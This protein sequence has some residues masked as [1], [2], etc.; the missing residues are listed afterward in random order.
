MTHVDEEKHP[1]RKEPA[2]NVSDSDD[3]TETLVN[4]SPFRPRTT[5]KKARDDETETLVN[6]SPFRPRT[7]SPRKARED[8]QGLD[9]SLSSKSLPHPFITRTS[10]STPPSPS[11]IPDRLVL[12]LHTT[13]APTPTNADLLLAITK[14]RQWER[15]ASDSRALKQ[16][17]LRQ[18]RTEG[19]SLRECVQ[20]LIN[21][22]YPSSRPPY[23]V[24]PPPGLFM[25]FLGLYLLWDSEPQP[26]EIKK[27]DRQATGPGY[28]GRPRRQKV[29]SSSWI[30]QML[31]YGSKRKERPEEEAE[32]V[33][34]RE[35]RPT[36]KL[37]RSLI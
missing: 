29:E 8:V 16:H 31:G 14:R 21:E 13:P 28:T 11:R 7:V 32:F 3:E 22:M 34:L 23:Y 36:K 26:N 12:N 10:S 2:A 35:G 15:F 30:W 9:A 4:S 1:S 5:P 6:I 33:A 24:K 18:K 37:R 27:P 25:S 17:F 19:M 20:W